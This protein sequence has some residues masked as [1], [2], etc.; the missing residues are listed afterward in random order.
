M[1]INDAVVFLPV[2]LQGLQSTLI[3]TVL[4]FLLSTVLGLVWVF[5][6]VSGVRLLDSSSRVIVNVL[7]GV[8][9]L[10]QLYYLYFV[11]PQLG[12][13]LS[14]MEAAVIGLGV[15]YSA[16]QAEIFRAGIEAIDQGQLEAAQSI[17]MGWGLTMRR[18]I[19][20]QAVRIILP[21]YGN[22]M[23][24]VLKS[25][26]LASTITVA[27]ITLQGD[28]LASSTFKNLSVYTLLALLYL[29]M[30]L[31]L[32]GMVSWLEKRFGSAGKR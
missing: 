8:P 11:M 3:V 20:P 17:G 16:Y 31:P 14:A 7:R 21:A 30:S 6:R 1:V 25:S 22:N 13:K 26:S 15:A 32:I 27:E 18:V 4:A 10:V 28:L 5:M 24:T 12:I 2:I 23:I 9:A 29:A 19:L